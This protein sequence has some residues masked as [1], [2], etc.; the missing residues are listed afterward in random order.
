MSSSLSRELSIGKALAAQQNQLVLF[1]DPVW[2]ELFDS[3]ILLTQRTALIIDLLGTDMRPQRLKS[4]I[5]KRLA[6]LGVTPHRP[7][8]VGRDYNAK[9]FISRNADRF[10]GAYLLALHFGSRGWGESAEVETNFRLALKK[11]LEVYNKYR[12]DLY[13]N[14]EPK[15]SF[16]TYVML[17]KGIKAAAIEVHTCPDCGSWHPVSAGLLSAAKCP[18]CA[19]L[20]LDMGQ[21]HERISGRQDMRRQSL[22]QLPRLTAVAGG[23]GA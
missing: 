10:D 16:E 8:G 11:R 12:G 4:V 14:T 1:R 15:L 7:R 21:A 6:D 23:A 13:P 20:D 19:T 18:V 3:L 5:D 22:R 17:I 2:E 9:G